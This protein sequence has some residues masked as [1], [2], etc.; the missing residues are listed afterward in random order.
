MVPNLVKWSSFCQNDTEF[1][2]P[3]SILEKKKKKR[4][5]KRK[6]GKKEDNVTLEIITGTSTVYQIH[7]ICID[8]RVINQHTMY[9]VLP[10]FSVSDFIILHLILFTAHLEKFFHSS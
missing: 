6:K 3:C 1:T 5:R 7:E 9:T 8:Q 10:E 2:F 4:K